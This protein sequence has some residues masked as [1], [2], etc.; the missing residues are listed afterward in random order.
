MSLLI[1]TLLIGMG[2]TLRSDDG[3]GAFI[4]AKIEAMQVEQLSTMIVQQ[5]QVE[6]IE[7]LLQFDAIIIVDASVGK[8]DIEF[9][10]LKT[11]E[12][13]TVSSSHHIN[14]AMLHALAEKVCGKK[15]NMYLCAVPAENFEIGE[16]LSQLA[17]IN[18][19]KAI[20]IIL[21]QIPLVSIKN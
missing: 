7:E 11:N 19:N 8:D 12:T 3:I 4:C 15:L 9:S 13:Q 14:A 1:K 10:A 18:A 20:K 16:T 17:L 2:N 5:L 6:I 21:Q